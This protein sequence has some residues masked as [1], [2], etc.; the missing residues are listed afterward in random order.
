M[1][2]VRSLGAVLGAADGGAVEVP[3]FV[4]GAEWQRLL[5]VAGPSGLMPALW[6]VAR[7]LDLLEPV[8]AELLDVLGRWLGRR[9]HVAAVLEYSYR[10]NGRRNV[11]LLEQLHDVAER[12]A[13]EDLVLVA[14]K[15]AGHILR[16][17]WADPADRMMNDLDLLVPAERADEAQALLKA[18]GYELAPGPDREPDQHHLPSLRLEHRFGAI[19]VHREPL[20]AAGPRRSPRAR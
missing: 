9:N 19:E 4:D 3:D 17:V 7:R 14:L 8:P 16:G 12:F 6:S 13:A 20:A 15:G 2:A 5:E 1:N 10:E 11:D 18:A